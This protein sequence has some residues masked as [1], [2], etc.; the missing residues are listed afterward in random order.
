MHVTM[1]MIMHMVIVVPMRLV[2]VILMG[3][4]VHC[5]LFYRI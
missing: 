3:M 5:G 4:H 2:P 1:T